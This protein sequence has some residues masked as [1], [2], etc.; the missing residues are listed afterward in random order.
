M[1]VVDLHIKQVE[2]L[3]MKS[4]VHVDL[5]TGY[6]ERVEICDGPTY[7]GPEQ[8]ED[9]LQIDSRALD[10]IYDI[11]CRACLMGMKR[12]RNIT[13]T[14]DEPWFKIIEH[15]SNV[16]NKSIKA[17]TFVVLHKKDAELAAFDYPVHVSVD[18]IHE[19]S[20]TISWF[21]ESPLSPAAFEVILE[22]HDFESSIYPPP[23]KVIRNVELPGNERSA[24][25]D[26]LISNK[27]YKLSF[28]AIG[29]SWCEPVN[30]ITRKTYGK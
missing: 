6:A 14:C 17:G 27:W 29:G 16:A 2:D 30:V 18:S 4:L 3:C 5:E 23:L 26:A 1:V 7:K 28:R 9:E 19:D 21:C 12:Y 20:V 10:C 13:R 22:E 8:L 11:V 25:I 15:L 24:E